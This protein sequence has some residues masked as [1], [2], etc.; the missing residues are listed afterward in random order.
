MCCR[1]RNIWI[2]GT[3]YI[4]Q[5][6]SL[7]ERRKRVTCEIHPNACHQNCLSTPKVK[8]F[9]RWIFLTT[10]TVFK[11][12]VV[13]AFR[14]SILDK[15]VMYI[16][17]LAFFFV[18]RS[19]FVQAGHVKELRE[20]FQELL[21]DM[22]G[23]TSEEKDPEEL[24]TALFGRI[25]EAEPLLAVRYDLAQLLCHF[26]L[27]LVLLKYRSVSVGS[28]FRCFLNSPWM[29]FVCL[30]CCSSCSTMCKVSDAEMFFDS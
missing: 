13:I 20:L 14:K 4:F 7:Q 29:I 8:T 22:P 17:I 1:A 10:I 19:H 12:F 24:L 18:F 30:H 3:L 15:F 16:L 27:R 23:F 11:T 28:P 6:A 5:H 25:F 21:P 2:W 26:F 9:I